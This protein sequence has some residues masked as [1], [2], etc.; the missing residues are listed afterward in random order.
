M[1]TLPVYLLSFFILILTHNGYTEEPLLKNGDF[2]EGAKYWFVLVNG[3]YRTDEQLGDNL[4]VNVGKSLS[5]R[6]GNLVTKTSA[7][8]AHV[9][10]NQRLT[11]LT[12]G[13]K[14]VLRFEVRSSE[15]GTLLAALGNPVL[16]GPHKFNVSG[17]FPLQEVETGP[18]WEKVEIEFIYNEDKSLTLPVDSEKTVLQL[19]AGTLTDLEVRSF[20]LE[21]MTLLP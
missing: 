11:S 18:K 3:G 17:G 16:T 10:L 8:S 19:R 15:P 4:D 5:L 1:K 20:S 14:Y 21:S 7:K 6:V 9:V 13:V 12:E 2:S